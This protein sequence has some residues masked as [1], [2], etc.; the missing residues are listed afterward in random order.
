MTLAVTAPHS[1][2][3]LEATRSFADSGAGNSRI[4]FYPGVMPSTGAG[5]AESVLCSV[6]LDKPCGVIASGV[7]TLSQL[8]TSGDMIMLTGEATWARWVNGDE[9]IMADGSVSDSAGTGD[10]KIAGATGTIIYAGARLV[11]GVCT[12]G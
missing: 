8:D 12:L 1:A 5:T 4:D 2:A 6:V 9:V 3:R 11:I 7:L 10:F